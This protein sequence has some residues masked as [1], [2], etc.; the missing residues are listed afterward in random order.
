MNVALLGAV[1]LVII[2]IIVATCYR[3]RYAKRTPQSVIFM[4][5]LSMYILQEWV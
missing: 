4:A 3:G 2:I 5:V 1:S